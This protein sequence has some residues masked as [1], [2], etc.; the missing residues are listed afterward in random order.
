MSSAIN[1]L[2]AVGIPLVIAAAV[3]ASCGRL[4]WHATGW[5]IAVPL[6]YVS[7]QLA[8][9]ARGGITA[10][11]AAAPWGAWLGSF[12]DH[13]AMFFRPHQ[14]RDW[15]PG[16]LLLAVV[17]ASL[18]QRYF[19]R[20]VWQWLTGAMVSGAACGRLLWQSIYLASEWTSMGAA[21]RLGGMG[22]VGAIVGSPLDLRHASVGRI[23]RHMTAIVMVAAAL[24][25][26]L[27]ASGSLIYG[28]LGT[29]A[30]VSLAAASGAAWRS[31][32][33]SAA[34]SV[35]P[36]LA[37]LL[38]S[39]VALGYF[40][41]ELTSINAGLLVAAL[42]VWAL[43]AHR[44]GVRDSK[45]WEWVRVA[46]CCGL[47]VAAALAAVFVLVGKLSGPAANPYL[48]LR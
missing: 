40:F 16:L 45:T 20:A 44:R 42:V 12:P 3:M 32:A 33:L 24:A 5:R 22:V 17:V 37:V 35:T 9:A 25:V 23:L 46:A 11:D 27:A 14:A 21:F 47:A 8:L 15:L 34:G 30:T 13:L 48:Q 4:G 38:G 26:T 2:S 6:G 10:D 39:L 28:E 41:A 29:A 19:P 7:G 36:V 18:Q 1:L 31:G 43:P